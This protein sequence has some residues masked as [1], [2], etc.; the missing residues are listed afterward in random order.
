MNGKHRQCWDN[1]RRLFHDGFPQLALHRALSRTAT[2]LN[3]DDLAMFLLKTQQKWPRPEPC[4]SW[5]KTFCQFTYDH[6]FLLNSAATRNFLL[7][8]S[9]NCLT[10]G[11]VKIRF[12]RQRSAMMEWWVILANLI[13]T[14]YWRQYS[15]AIGLSHQ[16][17]T[18]CD[19]CIRYERTWQ[20]HV[21]SYIT[22]LSKV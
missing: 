2:W 12:P 14:F 16:K 15:K 22:H 13:D 11:W 1:R 4:A 7:A 10:I 19:K 3:S 21:R 20:N 5:R 18:L 8:I 17:V 6:S 9:I